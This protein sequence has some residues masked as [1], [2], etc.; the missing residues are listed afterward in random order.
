MRAYSATVP[1]RIPS[2]VYTKHSHLGVT[3]TFFYTF[4]IAFSR[5][6]WSIFRSILG[7]F[8]VFLGVRGVP[9]PSWPQTRILSIF[10]KIWSACWLRLGRQDEA[11]NFTFML[12]KSFRGPPGGSGRGFQRVLNIHCNI[13]SSWHR[14]LVNFWWV[15]GGA[16]E[17]KIW[18]SLRSGYNFYIFGYLKI[19]CLLDP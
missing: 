9:G 15:L 6:F 1:S 11:Q 5:W 16:G 14:F 17:A 19:T 8:S 13:E 2:L 3:I 10:S 12:K 18:F 7:H 4:L